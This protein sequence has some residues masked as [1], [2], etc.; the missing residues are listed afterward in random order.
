[1]HALH[2]MQLRA[3]PLFIGDVWGYSPMASDAVHA[4]KIYLLFS[5]RKKI[6]LFL[7]GDEVSDLRGI[8]VVR[9]QG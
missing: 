9:R 8:C 3:D 6:N 1:M 5:A 7:L 4:I 2:Q